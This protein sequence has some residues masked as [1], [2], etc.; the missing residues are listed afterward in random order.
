M[1]RNI[2]KMLKVIELENSKTEDQEN[3]A[4]ENI[5]EVQSRNFIRE[6]QIQKNVIETTIEVA[7]EELLANEST[8]EKK[9]ECRALLETLCEIESE[10]KE[11]INRLKPLIRDDTKYR[12]EMRVQTENVR[13][14]LSY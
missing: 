7:A 4:D 1:I 8:F 9:I 11:L 14:G 3:I 12:N 13:R 2:E 5:E 6:R 10:I